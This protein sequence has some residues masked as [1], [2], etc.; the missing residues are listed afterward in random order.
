[1]GYQRTKKTRQKHCQSDKDKER[2]REREIDRQREREK[3]RERERER[4]KEKEKER[5]KGH[6]FNII[7]FIIKE[8]KFGIDRKIPYLK[9]EMVLSELSE[10]QLFTGQYL[11]GIF[12][13]NCILFK[14]I[15]LRNL[16]LER[17]I[18]TFISTT[19]GMNH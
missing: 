12:S 6:N 11:L 13:E 4:K 8:E 16:I 5:D 2:E 3:K 1:M 14:C 18:S 7:E 15:F 17:N 19:E 9:K 10:P